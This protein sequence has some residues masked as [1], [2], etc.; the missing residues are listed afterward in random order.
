MKNIFFGII[1]LLVAINLTA[2]DKKLP[3][4]N[5]KDV[6]GKSF[7][8]A[9]IS[10][11]G[12]PIIVNFWATWCKPCIQEL[13]NIGELYDKWQKETGV[14]IIA[15]SVDDSRSSKK[16]KPFVKGRDWKFDVLLDENSD[17]KRTM[18]V[19]APP[20]TFLLD[21]DGNI[22]YEHNGYAPGDEHKLYK[23]IKKIA[24]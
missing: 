15:V 5:I 9:T 13:S 20:H 17:F 22:V 3:S 19:N 14:K 18:N 4:V 1:F 21:G 24:K 16:V 8:T 10:N 12:K 6:N 11:D 2:A 7:N 23:E